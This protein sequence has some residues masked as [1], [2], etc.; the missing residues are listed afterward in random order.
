MHRID[1]PSAAPTL[2]APNQPG[3]PGYYTEGS[4]TTGQQATIVSADWAN[5]VQEEL[6]YV[7]EQS[8]LTLSKTDRTQLYQ[9]IARLT[10]QR[11]TANTIFYISS[12]GSDNN[13]GL[14]T[15]TPWGT[16]THAYNFIRDR[17]DGNG[18]SVTIQLMDGTHQP[19]TCV[20]PS[21]S[22]TPIINGN[23]SDPSRVIVNNPSGPAIG[24]LMGGGVQVQN[25]TVQAAGPEGD[26][27]SVGS[28]LLANTSPSVI[29]IGPGMRF[30]PCTTAHI[31]TYEGGTI[32]TTV[33]NQAYTIFGGGERHFLANGGFITIP[34]AV[35]TLQ[36]TPAFSVAFAHA[37]G[38]S[39]VAWKNTWTGAATGPRYLAA[40]AGVINTAGGGANYLPGS[41]AG[42]VD[43]ATYGIYV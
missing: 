21:V 12:T 20:F 9:A 25:F 37:Q 30:G 8:G 23:A 13:D 2:P 3:T 38:G 27:G 36:N 28:G 17:I 6:A 41:A 10:R 29:V 11:L 35:I 18:Y 39:I 5:A 34:D 4:P 7:V 43:T 19:A 14:T 22:V 33:A 1:D 16:I 15:A 42:T 32:L 40:L 26:F 24:A 31:Q